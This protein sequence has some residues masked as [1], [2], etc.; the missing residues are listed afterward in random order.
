MFQ[1]WVLLG[2]P[3][4]GQGYENLVQTR[5]QS[6][7]SLKFCQDHTDQT[8]MDRIAPYHNT[9]NFRDFWKCTNSFSRSPRLM[10]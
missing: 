7:N 3:S 6:K 10:G 8:A 9:N 5:K 2:K 1:A 4:Q